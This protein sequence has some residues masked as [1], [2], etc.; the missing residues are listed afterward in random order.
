MS[1][2]F[3]F[4][5]ADDYIDVVALYNYTA[6]TSKEVSFNKGDMIRVFSRTNSDWWDARVNGKFGFVPVQYVKVLERPVSVSDVSQ[7]GG[8][9]NLSPEMLAW[10]ARVLAQV[11][12][13]GNS[14]LARAASASGGEDSS[15][16]TGE[17]HPPFTP[18][19]DNRPAGPTPT[20]TDQPT[21]DTDGESPRAPA[22]GK[23]EGGAHHQDI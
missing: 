16:Q 7:G 13:G 12:L 21:D 10:F 5:E 2:Y 11:P 15:G 9:L 14:P 8:G 18:R 22:A 3:L 4:T 17:G 20:P 6:R 1:F 23:S 19:Q